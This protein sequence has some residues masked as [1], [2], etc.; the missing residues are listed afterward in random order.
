VRCTTI[1]LPPA[2]RGEW[3]TS[4]DQQLVRLLVHGGHD[5][6]A[7][8]HDRY[9]RL[10]L[11]VAARHLDRPAAEEIVQDVFVAVWQHAR[12]FDPDRGSFRVWVLQIARRRI[13][14]E[15]RRRRYR[16]QLE[17]GPQMRPLDALP[18][19]R[20]DVVE[21][22]VRKERHAAVRG[23]LRVLP[24]LQ[25]QAVALAFLEELTHQEVAAQLQAPLGTAKTRIRTGLMNLRLELDA[26]RPEP[27]V[28]AVGS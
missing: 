22:V 20:P 6:L 14:N 1:N 25:R 21:Q 16:P 9:G 10:L 28:S 8:L 27:R 24:R 2:P 11:N 17:T 3:S 4:S 13:S 5:A 19:A 23:A 12:R 18:D 26:W 15:L 7:A